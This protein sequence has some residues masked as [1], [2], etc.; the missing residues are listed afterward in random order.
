MSSSSDECY[1]VRLPNKSLETL[2]GPRDRRGIWYIAP[3]K[4]GTLLRCMEAYCW[5]GYYEQNHFFRRFAQAPVVLEVPRVR[6][7]KKSGWALPS[8]RVPCGEVVFGGVGAGT[9]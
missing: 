4:V 6:A 3:R 8:G 2:P 9:R 7:Q 1:I 5:A